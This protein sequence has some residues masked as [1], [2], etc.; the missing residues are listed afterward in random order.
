MTTRLAACQVACPHRAGLSCSSLLLALW[1][2]CLLCGVCGAGGA[3][4]RGAGVRPGIM[5]AAG[6]LILVGKGHHGAAPRKRGD[7]GWTRGVSMG[8]AGHTWG[9]PRTRGD[10]GNH[11]GMTTSNLGTAVPNLGT[12]APTWGW[13]LT[14]GDGRQNVGME[15]NCLPMWAL[16]CLARRA[17]PQ[18]HRSSPTCHGSHQTRRGPPGGA[19]FCPSSELPPP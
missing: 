12:A 3:G 15:N 2:C 7:G 6:A 5:R 9:W 1:L 11:V 14:P 4:G 16:S 10:G 13:R 19:G 17:A 8:M 18:T